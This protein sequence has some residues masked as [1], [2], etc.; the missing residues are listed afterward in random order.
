G[1][2]RTPGA[3]LADAPAGPGR[4]DP[5]GGSQSA[6]EVRPA[7]APVA[8]RGRK[9]PALA[10]HLIEFDA[11]ASKHPL[12]RRPEYHRPAIARGGMKDGAPSDERVEDRHAEAAG[13]MVVA[14]ARPCQRRG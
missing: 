8:A 6:A 11:E 2:D 14:R 5:Q 3:G 12:A 13:E 10:V 9:L 1:T 7:L 4:R